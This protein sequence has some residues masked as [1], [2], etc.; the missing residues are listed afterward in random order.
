MS[1]LWTSAEAEAATLGAAGT[2]CGRAAE[3]PA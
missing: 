1:V 3:V 2:P